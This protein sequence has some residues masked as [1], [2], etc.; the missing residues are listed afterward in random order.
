MAVLDPDLSERDADRAVLEEFYQQYEK[1]LYQAALHY[2]GSPARAEDAFHE[3]MVKIILHFDDLKRLRGSHSALSAWCFTIIKNVC[4]S[5]LRKEKPLQELPEDWDPPAPDDV[6]STD[7]FHRLVTLIH[8]LPET[9]RTVLEL[10][11][12][13]EWSSR[14]IA[15][16]LHL[17]V[18]NVDVR[19][20]RGRAMLAQRL[21]QEGYEIDDL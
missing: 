6:E 13:S 9:Y 5:M 19:I 11:L 1:K 3:A 8:A 7:A 16:L 4:L 20:S 2:L 12:I 10:R 21:R 15:A 14:D 17:S 18:S